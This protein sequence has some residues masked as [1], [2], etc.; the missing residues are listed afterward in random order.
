MCTF[1]EGVGA[2]SFR[3]ARIK[4][5]RDGSFFRSGSDLINPVLAAESDGT[6]YSEGGGGGG[7]CVCRWGGG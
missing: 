5:T 4:R 6:A 7:V 3:V 2:I 1:A